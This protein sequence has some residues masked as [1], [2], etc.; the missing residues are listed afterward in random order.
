MLAPNQFQVRLYDLA[1]TTARKRRDAMLSRSQIKISLHAPKTASNILSDF[2]N[3]RRWVNEWREFEPTLPQG[4]VQWKEKQCHPHGVLNYPVSVTVPSADLLNCLS[5]TERDQYS[6]FLDNFNILSKG[7]EKSIALDLLHYAMLADELYIENHRFCLQLNTLLHQLAP[8]VG[9]GQ[10]VR[11]IPFK[12]VHSK[13]LE[14]HSS[15]IRLLYSSIAGQSFSTHESLLEYLDAKPIPYPNIIVFAFDPDIKKQL[16]GMTQIALSS[17]AIHQLNVNVSNVIVVENHE[18]AYLFSNLKDTIVFAGGGKDTTFLMAPFIHR[19]ENIFY[20]GDIDTHGFVCLSSARKYCPKL[21]SFLMSKDVFLKYA[22]EYAHQETSIS[23]VEERYLTDSELD[24]YRFIASL[25]N[26]NRL[27]QQYI[28]HNEV[29]KF[30][31]DKG[32]DFIVF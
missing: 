14:A 16:L 7:F 19:A 26:R 24:T 23:P 30:C 5:D 11:S 2:S 28:P 10:F 21:D 17:S 8:G 1:W 31:V 25:K 9:A 6:S 27:E 18:S 3:F 13:F 22:Q 15:I 20:W 12:G 4:L 29:A 32:F